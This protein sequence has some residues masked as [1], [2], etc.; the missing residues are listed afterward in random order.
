VVVTD[1]N[2]LFGGASRRGA[3]GV[4]V[5]GRG[6]ITE[7]T[8]PPSKGGELKMLLFDP[9]FINLQNPQD[10]CKDM[11]SKGRSFFLTDNRKI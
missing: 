10:V 4:R 1:R 9:N 7:P 8:T 6:E 3:L 2:L 5:E 11:L